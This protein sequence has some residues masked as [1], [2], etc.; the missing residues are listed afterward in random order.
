M[1]TMEEYLDWITSAIQILPKEIVIH[2]LTG[3][4]ARDLLTAPLWSRNKRHVLNSLHKK[5]KA[6]HIYQGQKAELVLE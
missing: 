5:M 3:D 1:A 2:R 4:G 6:E